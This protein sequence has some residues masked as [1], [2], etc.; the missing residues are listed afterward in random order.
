MQTLILAMTLLQNPPPID[1][2]WKITEAHYEIKNPAKSENKNII[3][4]SMVG[5]FRVLRNPDAQNE[6]AFVVSKYP[7]LTFI[8]KQIQLNENAR[9][10]IMVADNYF[11]KT[12]QDKLKEKI[13]SSDM[14]LFIKWRED[15]DQ[16]TG[17]KI[18]KGPI[19]SWLLNPNGKWIFKE[20]RESLVKI[21]LL[22]EG[23]ILIGF[24]FS[25]EEN[26]HILRFDQI[27]IGGEK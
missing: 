14:I 9:D 12:K 25:L 20:S 15:K 3:A 5:F 27:H 26:Y 21:E 22:S 8:P 6:F 2:W 7:A 16:R 18:L 24:K 4:T 1:N 17:E 10:E 13:N 23:A 11:K 19:E